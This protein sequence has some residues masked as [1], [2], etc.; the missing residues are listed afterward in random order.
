MIENQEIISLE[1]KKLSDGGYLL[2]RSRDW[3][4][5]SSGWMPTFACTTIDEAL[6]YARSKLAAPA[7]DEAAS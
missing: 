4:E 2:G 3:R 7:D 6:K 5:G 1:I